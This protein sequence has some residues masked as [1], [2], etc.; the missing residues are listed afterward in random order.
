M[1]AMTDFAHVPGD[2]VTLK[3]L[4]ITGTV[5]ACMVGIDGKQYQ[6]VYWWEGTRRC[7]WL[8]AFEIGS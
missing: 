6:V 1:E 4:K 8:H 7:E 2:T 5:T 3:G